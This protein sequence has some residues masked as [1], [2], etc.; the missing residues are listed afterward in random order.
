MDGCSLEKLVLLLDKKL[1]LD[2]K[3]GV[4]DHLDRCWYCKEAI[5]MIARSRDRELFVRH[6]AASAA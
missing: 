2:T 1:S 3:L 4:F 6:R 5:Y